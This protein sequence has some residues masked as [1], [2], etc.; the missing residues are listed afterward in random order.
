MKI[1][2]PKLCGL[3]MGC[4]IAA[5]PAPAQTLTEAITQTVTTNPDLLKT[6][7]ERMAAEQ[8]VRQAR[9]GYLPTIDI[10]AGWGG[11]EANNTSTRGRFDPATGRHTTLTTG[12]GTLRGKSFRGSVNMIREELGVQIRQMIFDGFMT[13]NEVRRKQS[14]LEAQSWLVFATAEVLAQEATEAYLNVL[15]EQELVALA[16]D[17]LAVH[18]RTMDQIKLRSQVGVGRKA[19]ETQAE[20][21]VSQARVNLRNEEANLADAQSKFQRLI[22]ELPQSLVTP[23]L[24]KEALPKTLDEAINDAVANHPQ[25]KSA[26]ADIAEADAQHDVAVAPFYPRVDAEASANMLSNLNG[27]PGY[28]NDYQAMLRLRY[29]IFKGGKDE[30][31]LSETAHLKD[32]AREIRN[33]T[34][35][36]V[37]ESMRLSWSDYQNQNDQLEVVKDRVDSQERTYQAYQ[38]QFNLGERTLLDLLDTVNELFVARQTYTNTMHDELIARSRVL[39]SKGSLNSTL[40]VKLPEEAKPTEARLLPNALPDLLP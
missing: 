22:G 17:N 11:E 1:S 36:Q 24:P 37:V 14:D 5:P 7:T 30:A 33:H 39:A 12:S 9:A 28:N 19:D 16:K 6:T 31:R 38:Q 34:Y 13:P 40:Q 8:R 15:R 20:S 35:R 4:L 26:E 2:A 25:L 32:Q 29:N 21:R 23:N 10:N 18:E 27:V 3:A